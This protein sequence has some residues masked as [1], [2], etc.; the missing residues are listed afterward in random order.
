[1]TSGWGEQVGAYAQAF[2]SGGRGPTGSCSGNRFYLW[3]ARESQL[4]PQRVGG[5]QPQHPLILRERHVI[6]LSSTW[7]FAYPRESFGT[8]AV[9]PCGVILGAGAEGSRTLSLSWA[10]WK[11]RTGT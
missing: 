5:A 1:M 8:A 10:A 2:F 7:P 6:P 3:G 11:R 4:R 9:Y